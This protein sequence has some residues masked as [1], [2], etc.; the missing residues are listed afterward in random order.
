VFRSTLPTLA[1][2]L[3]LAG[4]AIAGPVGYLLDRNHS[5]VAFETDF[6]P[7]VITG[8]IPLNSADL[9]LDFDQAQNSIIAVDLDA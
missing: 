3:L 7:G 1:A 9:T 8:S 5:I 2:A 6:R 4:P